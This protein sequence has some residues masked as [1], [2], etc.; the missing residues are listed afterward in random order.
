[1]NQQL[2]FEKNSIGIKLTTK[3]DM[4]LYEE[5][6]LNQQDTT[7]DQFLKGCLIGLNSD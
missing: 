4:P 7:Q 3:V 5:T 1:M 2:F 6:N